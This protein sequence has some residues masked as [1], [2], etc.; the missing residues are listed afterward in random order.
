MAIAQSAIAPAVP[1]AA[2]PG[3]FLAL[4]DIHLA[5]SDNV[6]CSSAGEETRPALWSAAQ[7][8][9]K[10]LI[11]TAKPAFAIY[12]GDLPAHCA[13]G[14][15]T[16]FKAA[17][18]GLA[19]IAG[20]TTKLIYL[21]G[22]NDS[23]GGDYQAFT[24]NQQ[25]PLNL[26]STWGGSPVL[27]AQSGDLI[28]TANL[29]KGYYSVYAAQKS[30][31]AP[32]L[33]VIALNTNIFTAS[34]D[35][36]NGAPDPNG[37]PHYQADTNIFTASY[38]SRNGAPDPNGVPH[39]QAD[40]NAQLEWLNAQLKDA[41]TKGERVI[42]AMHVPPGID[43]YGDG[44]GGV[45]TMWSRSLNYTGT[46]PDLVQAWVQQTF[47]QIIASYGPEIVGLL[48]SHTHYNEIRRLRD[49]SRKLPNLGRFTELDLAIPSITT[50]HGNNPSLKLV[51]YNTQFEWTENTTYYASDNKGTGW[52]GNKP[53]SFD[54]MNY[55]CKKCAPG[56][57]LKDRIAA[58][59]NKTVIG[60]SQGLA[61]LMLK[62]LRVNGTA[63][64]N[65]R[66]YALS[67]DA[68]CEAPD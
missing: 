57:T 4:S 34:Y 54:S 49:C 28:D 53:L 13:G 52:N 7:A 12:V 25:T 63:P 33:R 51:E 35:S 56:D 36:R 16:E 31:T 5:M 10:V 11:A 64:K 39:Y 41:R 55:P 42:V 9:A 66:S 50:D 45:K 61:D 27:N 22:N 2:S 23:L 14:Y 20:T 59:D 40:T 24:Y 6:S 46:D 19:N 1:A 29:P 65:P 38:D 43:G 58:L 30:A 18:D 44:N 62:W 48:S 60:T 3:T 47:L 67:L 32:A 21:P 26:S 17:L 15:A 37:V 68:T 8:K